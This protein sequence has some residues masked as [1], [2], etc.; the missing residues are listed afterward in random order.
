MTTNL[1]SLAATESAFC[2]IQFNTTTGQQDILSWNASGGAR[3]REYMLLNTKMALDATN[4]AIYYS[5]TPSTGVKGLYY[6]DH[7]TTTANLFTNGTSDYSSSTGAW[8]FSAGTQG[9][10]IGSYGPAGAFLNAT[11]YEIVVYNSVLSTV[12]RQIVEGWLAWKWGIQASLPA[13]HPYKSVGPAQNPPTQPVVSSS[14]ITSSGFTVSWTGG[15]TATSYTYTLNGGSVTPSTD[16]GVASNTAVF[17]GLSGGTT[18]AVVVT[19]VNPFGSTASSSINVATTLPTGVTTFAGQ[20]NVTGHATGTGTANT[21]NVPLGASID[22]SGNLYVSNTYG[23]FITKLTP[24]GVG[25]IFT[26]GTFVAGNANGTSSTATLNGP[27][28]S[29]IYNGYL[30]V[31]DSGSGNIRK[32]S[33]TDGSVTTLASAVGANSYITSDGAGNFYFSTQNN[34]NIYKVNSSGTVTTYATAA[35]TGSTAYISGL[36]YNPTNGDIYYVEVRAGSTASSFRKITTSLVNTVIESGIN[37]TAG[38]KM[39]PNNTIVYYAGGNNQVIKKY[40]IGGSVSVV[41]GTLN[42]SGH[43]DSTTLTSATFSSLY[44]VLA[45]PSGLFLYAIDNGNELIRKIVF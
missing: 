4:T 16:N 23:N 28:G 30:Y 18:Y 34:G 44:D 19:A 24:A 36:A 20:Y 12:N 40:V 35:Q 17:T 5:T 13:N 22:A 41:A 1:N 21:F 25:T 39:S 7:T 37:F 10:M 43:A 2:V 14:S 3:A 27:Y 11:I 42:T 31:C 45:D 9:T 29:C 15:A 26:G 8:S 32:V 33:L 6:Y 38:V